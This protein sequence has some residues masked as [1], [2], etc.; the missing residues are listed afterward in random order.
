MRDGRARG[1]ADDIAHLVLVA[2]KSSGKNRCCD[3]ERDDCS[4]PLIASGF[5]GDLA[6]KVQRGGGAP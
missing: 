6:P 4:P 2:T 1:A 5:F 3:L